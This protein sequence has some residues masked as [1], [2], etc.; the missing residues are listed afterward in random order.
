MN[1]RANPFEKPKQKITNP[2]KNTTL[3]NT[4]T[5]M[6]KMNNFRDQLNN[7]LFGDSDETH[8]VFGSSSLIQEKD[9]E[10][11]KEYKIPPKV[12]K[13]P[14]LKLQDQAMNIENPR[15]PTAHINPVNPLAQSD[16]T[17]LED[18]FTS[19]KSNRKEDCISEKEKS[20]NFNF[21]SENVDE[22]ENFNDININ[23][24]I[25]LSS[26]EKNKDNIS[27]N[28]SNNSQNSNNQPNMSFS[29]ENCNSVVYSEHKNDPI[30]NQNF[31]ESSHLEE[32]TQSKPNQVQGQVNQ[33]Y[34]AS[35]SQKGDL[36][37]SYSEVNEEGD[38]SSTPNL[39]KQ[40][41][42]S[43]YK[44]EKTTKF[45]KSVDS[46]GIMSSSMGHTA[47][48]T[49]SIT[50]TTNKNKMQPSMNMNNTSTY[51]MGGDAKSVRSVRSVKTISQKEKEKFNSNETSPLEGLTN[52]F[53]KNDLLSS[54]ENKGM[55]QTLTS[56]ELSNKLEKLKNEIIELKQS[57]T[58]LESDYNIELN[59]TKLY[60]KE[61]EELRSSIQI[62][63]QKEMTQNEDMLRLEIENL[64]N[65]VDYKNKENDL[66]K[67]ENI[68]L[69]REIKKLQK[70]I[71]E[72]FNNGKLNFDEFM[73]QEKDKELIQEENKNEIFEGK[74]EIINNKNLDDIFIEQYG[75]YQHNE[76]NEEIE[77][78]PEQGKQNE[79]ENYRQNMTSNNNLVEE[80]NDEQISEQ[81]KQFTNVW[82][83]VSAEHDNQLKNSE[84]IYENYENLTSENKQT[85]EDQNQYEEESKN[86]QEYNSTEPEKIDTYNNVPKN[87]ENETVHHVLFEEQNSQTEQTPIKIQEK[88]HIPIRSKPQQMFNDVNAED[89]FGS[90]SVNTIQAPIKNE[91][92]DIFEMSKPLSTQVN[93]PRDKH[94][95]SN[96]FQSQHENIKT[97]N[98]KQQH[99]EMP[100]ENKSLNN[101]F[102]ENTDDVEDIF[103][104]ISQKKIINKDDSGNTNSVK[105]KSKV[106]INPITPTHQVK[107]NLKI[108]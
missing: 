81:H 106:T 14:E 43:M 98:V 83:E 108:F 107:K 80:K 76:K 89:L 42:G 75:A 57:K 86:E 20:D 65:N 52:T 99:Q 64:R 79:N 60:E 105:S 6:Q 96:L 62:F 59:K 87:T 77:V 7:Q 74:E 39:G 51:S 46:K 23:Q 2:P 15:V 102:D 3:A 38:G 48:P 100:T 40:N 34:S 103:S 44:I 29:E 66:L 18:F 9:S 90:N 68:T 25:Q 70:Y 41:S 24:K 11:K 8:D 92:D 63:K 16:D 95:N 37:G 82:D 104:S 94:I 1:S 26:P 33:F 36:Y 49:T 10:S 5:Q 88:K 47:K 73:N 61:L 85:E 30:G 93:Q 84:N 19:N 58:S 27:P 53:G 31:T 91:I 69:S 21:S 28:N 54:Q 45:T 72:F 35:T 71:R 12:F 97:L 17:K 50:V 78:Q 13:R 56:S 55:L 101:I 22:R 67:R 4:K 32:K